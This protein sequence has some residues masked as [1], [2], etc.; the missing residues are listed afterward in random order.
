MSEKIV[1][2]NIT[3]FELIGDM[4]CPDG[5][6]G[7][8]YLV[9]P[10]KSK[11]AEL[12]SMIEHRFDYMY[13]ENLSDEEVEKAKEFHDQIW[14]HILDFIGENFITLDIDETYEIAY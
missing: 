12:K 14:G 8:Y 10:D 6:L 7:T 4:E 2:L 1:Q 13:D 11:L 5:I 9:N 3:D